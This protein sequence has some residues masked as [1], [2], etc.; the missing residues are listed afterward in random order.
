MRS[1]A[2]WTTA[3]VGWLRRSGSREG[4]AVNREDEGRERVRRGELLLRRRGAKLRF[5]GQAVRLDAEG[6]QRSA[7]SHAALF[8]AD[9]TVD[10]RVGWPN[11]IEG[12]HD[13]VGL[14]DEYWI[15]MRRA[16]DICRRCGGHLGQILGHGPG[17]DRKRFCINACELAPRDE[18]RQLDSE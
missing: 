8:R 15:G 10:L 17:A 12:E 14:H 4:A 2:T 6:T 3:L 18:G 7:A 11:L 5:S 13:G 16:E 1:W 9:T